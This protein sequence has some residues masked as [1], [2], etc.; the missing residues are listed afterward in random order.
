MGWIIAAS[1]VCIVLLYLL[2]AP[3]VLVMDSARGIYGLRFHHL[4]SLRLVLR[5]NF[6]VLKMRA[7]GIPFE[8]RLLPTEKPADIATR[9]KSPKKR[10]KS[11]FRVKALWHVCKSFRVRRCVIVMNVADMVLNGLMFPL[12]YWIGRWSGREI[13]ISFWEDGEMDVELENTAARMLYA[14]FIK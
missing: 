8:K 11:R 12:L 9:A 4:F 1:A 14:Y 13:R 6:I 3:I 7:A 5:D 10:K 2:F